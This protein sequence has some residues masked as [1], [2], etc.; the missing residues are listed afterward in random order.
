[1]QLKEDLRRLI[2]RAGYRADCEL[3]GEEILNEREVFMDNKTLCRACAGGAY[4]ELL[5]SGKSQVARDK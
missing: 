1:V 5:Q 4:Y 3:C 2:S